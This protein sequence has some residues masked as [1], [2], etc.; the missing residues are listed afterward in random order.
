MANL[1]QW[2]GVSYNKK[3]YP[4]WA[5]LLGWMM[6][7]ASM[8]LIPGFAIHQLWKTPGTLQEVTFFSQFVNV[9][10][11]VTCRLHF[12]NSSKRRTGCFRRALDFL[13]VHFGRSSVTLGA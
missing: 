7:L 5:E 2:N 8:L 4:A 11:A 6:A 1:I 10:S 3:P 13:K 9:V 12:S